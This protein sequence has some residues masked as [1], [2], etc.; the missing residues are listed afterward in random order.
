[1][2]EISLT[3]DDVKR[4]RD[5]LKNVTSLPKDEAALLQGLLAKADAERKPAAAGG[6]WT[7]N[8]TYRF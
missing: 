3:D 8:W 2:K 1:M 4:I 7:F 6:T 5:K